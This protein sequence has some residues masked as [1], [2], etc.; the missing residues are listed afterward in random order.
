MHCQFTENVYF[1]TPFPREKGGEK[2]PTV[3]SHH[4]GITQLV[5]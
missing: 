1:C 2:K 5:E 3:L 4:A